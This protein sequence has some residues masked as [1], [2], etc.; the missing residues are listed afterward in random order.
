[1]QEAQF[2]QDI[3][4]SDFM[5]IDTN[6]LIA[7]GGVAKKY[8]KNESVFSEDEHANFYYQI[9]EGQVKLIN[10]Y[11]DGREFIQG[12]FY[13]GCSFGEPPLFVDVTYPSSAIAQKD[14]VIIKLSRV[15]FFKMLE[16]YPKIKSD[17]L[18]ALSERLHNKS[19]T[20]RELNH[21]SP[22]ERILSFLNF[23]KGKGTVTKGKVLV[24]H[25]RQEIADFTGLRVETVIRTLKKMETGK[26]VEI[27][28]HKLYF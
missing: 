13:D 14:S 19:I 7:W 2:L 25:T 23:N 28:N 5:Q 18:R 17:L 15:S 24:D 22:E 27:I 8:K 16:D 3:N 26:Q 21:N 11:N 9:L 6:I 12:I 4:K 20:A 10:R 1:M